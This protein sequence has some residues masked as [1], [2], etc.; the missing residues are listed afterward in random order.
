MARSP[1][2]SVGCEPVKQLT[3]VTGMGIDVD[4]APEAIHLMFSKRGQIKCQE[5][6]DYHYLSQNETVVS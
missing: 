3:A 5:Q 1:S 6:G 4:G 2:C